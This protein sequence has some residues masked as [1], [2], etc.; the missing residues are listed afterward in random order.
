MQVANPPTLQE[1]FARER[2]LLNE[3]EVLKG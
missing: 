3:L 2:Q 1:L